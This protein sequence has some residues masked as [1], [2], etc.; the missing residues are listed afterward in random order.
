MDKEYLKDREQMRYKENVERILWNYRRNVYKA[1]ELREM[2]KDITSVSGQSYGGHIVNGVSSPVFEVVNRKLRMEKKLAGTEKKIRVV[3]S[4]IDS[5]DEREL[6]MYQV[7]RILRSRYIKHREPDSVM[8][9]LVLTK[10][11]YYRR[12]RELLRRAEKFI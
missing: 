9:E 4:L 10:T 1:S 7:L 8:R 2:I 12:N 11:T 5:L 6:E 3:D